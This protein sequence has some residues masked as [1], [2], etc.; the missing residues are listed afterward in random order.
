MSMHYL[1]QG[2]TFL[3]AGSLVDV[4]GSRRVFVSGCVLQIICY[5]ACGFTQSGMQLIAFRILSG[6]AYPMCFVS[7]MNIHGE[8]LLAGHLSDLALYCTRGGQYLGSVAGMILSGV[9]SVNIGWRWGFQCAAV[10]SML[11]LLLS[12]WVIPKL[13]D[14]KRISWAALTEDIDWAGTLLATSLMAFLFYALAYVS[15]RST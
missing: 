8:I 15:L 4:L 5:L 2:C 13:P 7:A 9:F 10:L 14:T 1:A 6:V 11:I 12:I 3:L